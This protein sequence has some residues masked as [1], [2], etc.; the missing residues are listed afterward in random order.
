MIV[1]EDVVS[2]IF[3][4]LEDVGAFTDK[5]H[6]QVITRKTHRGFTYLPP[7]AN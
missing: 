7:N 3:E 4:A 2:K 5:Y 1:G 6:G